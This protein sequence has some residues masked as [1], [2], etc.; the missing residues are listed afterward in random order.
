MSSQPI[1]TMTTS[2]NDETTSHEQLKTVCK[3]MSDYASTL[4]SCGATTI[5]IEKNIERIARKFETDVQLTVLPMHIMVT[6]W[7]KAHNHSYTINEKVKGNGI[8]FDKNTQLSKLSWTI[9]DNDISLESAKEMMR[10]IMSCKRLN[11]VLV[12]L[13]TGAANTSFCKLFGGDLPSMLIV[14][15]ATICGFYV[16]NKLHG[17]W[18]CDLRLVTII[19]GCIATVI[20]SAGYVFHVGSTPDIALGTGVLFL[21]PGVPFI[22]SFNDLINGHY[23]CAFSRFTQAA[24]TTVCLS[25]GLCLG[26]L[27][28]NIRII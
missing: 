28:I 8:D 19:S 13:L 25:L 14:F 15:I 2:C 18:K 3:F 11:P 24:I 26:Y 16:K 1:F 27:I 17:E 23:I 5:R 4:F 20:A 22:N 9:F 10:E 12:T 21:V 6:V 7:D